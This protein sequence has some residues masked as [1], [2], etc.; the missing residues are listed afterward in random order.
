MK[1]ET[2]QAKPIGVSKK[3]NESVQRLI[4]RF[5]KVFNESGVIE[6]YK[7]RKFFEKKSEKKRREKKKARLR[8]KK[9]REHNV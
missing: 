9:Q 2:F 1:L 5:K 6:E 8:M 7:E 4:S 3:K